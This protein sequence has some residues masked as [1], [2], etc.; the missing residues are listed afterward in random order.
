MCVCVVYMEDHYHKILSIMC[1]TNQ[2]A[3]STTVKEVAAYLGPADI[4]GQLS[5]VQYSVM[6]PYNMLI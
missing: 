3:K 5:V 4:T 2:L 6:V 1:N